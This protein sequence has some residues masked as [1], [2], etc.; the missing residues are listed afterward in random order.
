M[1]TIKLLKIVCDN[2]KCF[3]HKEVELSDRTIVKGKNG[4]GKSTLYNALLFCLFDKDMNGNSATDIRPHDENGV[5]I[6]NIDISVSCTFE[7]DGREI[8]LKKTQKQKWTKK[9]GSDS[10]TFEG[11]VNEF[12]VNDI[13]KSQK[14]YKAYIADNFCDEETFLS[15][16]NA[17][18][19]FR[20]D[21]KKRRAK[22]L[23]LA[24][25]LTDEDVVATEETFKPLADMLKDGTVDELMTRSKG[26]I[27]RLNDTLKTLPARID[28]Q[29][30]SKVDIDV[31]ELELAKNAMK[32]KI[33]KIES[34]EADLSKRYEEYQ[35]ASDGVLEIKFEMSDLERKANE[36]LVKRKQEIEK[37]ICSKNV[38]LNS[39]KNTIFKTEFNLEGY[40]NDIASGEKEKN[41]LSEQWK[42]V[43][44]ETFDEFTA[45]CPTCHRELPEEDVK[46]LVD[47]FEKSKAER[48]AKIEKEGNEVKADIDN[49]K[50]NIPKVEAELKQQTA[51]K[52]RLEED[53][54]ALEK[55]L[56]DLPSEGDISDNTEYQQLAKQL[57]EKEAFLK[58]GNSAEETRNQLLSKKSDLQ[59]QLEE[60]N[61]Q[62]AKAQRNVDIDERIGELQQEQ[63]DTAQK[64]A[65]EERTL[66]LLEQF[67]RAKMNMLTDKINGHFK[68]VKWK[69]FKSLLNGGTED[70]CRA[71]VG[72]TDV[73]SG[74]ND[75]DCLLAYIDILETFQKMNNLSIPLFLDRGESINSDRL[76]KT[77]CQLIVL[78]VSEDK[79]M[80][81]VN[82]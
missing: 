25:A 33:A 26:T 43:K 20:L 48:L 80:M 76:P 34:E 8:T 42:S 58:K 19:F 38:S 28:E 81:V 9:R 15:C 30:K 2:F 70:I 57:E 37:Q 35:K 73:E 71:T 62:I 32:E 5:D 7:V 6:D 82:E 64:I 22:L 46:R 13:P 63:R 61:G 66:D 23:D 14:D 10:K 16:T 11:N 24:G 53:I 54:T 36:S 65:D 40:K 18:S 41:R 77:G 39:F 44:L 55:Q 49:A 12:T 51:E 56:S 31:A 45:I 74:L 50:A 47:D 21:T 59:S 75:S 79:G 68:M 52:N 17:Q 67:N 4:V 78:S 69:L 29:E 60:I 1:R 72:G 3:K 27:K